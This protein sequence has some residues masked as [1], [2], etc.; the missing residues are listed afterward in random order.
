MAWRIELY[1]DGERAS[2]RAYLQV[3]VEELPRQIV[4]LF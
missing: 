1:V 3:V 2:F 4:R